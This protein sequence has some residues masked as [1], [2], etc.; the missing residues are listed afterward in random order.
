[1]SS[2]QVNR[3]TGLSRATSV[4]AAIAAAGLLSLGVPSA[5]FAAAAPQTLG[6]LVRAGKRESVLAA[7]TSPDVDVNEKAP[8]GSTAL[9]WAVFNVDH[10][11][12]RALLKAG[13]KADLINRYG[14]S[15]LGE[16]VKLNDLELGADPDVVAKAL[17]KPILAF[18]AAAREALL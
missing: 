14:A 3:R 6:D 16:A 17:K 12:V 8:D 10:E 13:A 2:N 7:I 9:M 4:L 1:M 5:G 18:D 15:A 11:M